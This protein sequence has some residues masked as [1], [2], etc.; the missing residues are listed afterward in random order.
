MLETCLPGAYDVYKG[1]LPGCL[2]ARDSRRCD[3]AWV[4]KWLNRGL[5]WRPTTAS[6]AAL[7]KKDAGLYEHGCSDEPG[8]LTCR[9]IRGIEE[10]KDRDM[11]RVSNIEPCA[12]V[13]AVAD[14][15]SLNPWWSFRHIG[16]QIGNLI[17]LRV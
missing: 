7:A 1:R 16:P 8:F 6:S 4:G 12:V 5:T 11:I 9:T 3:D 10:K 17:S 15:W 14:S 13:W 2:Y